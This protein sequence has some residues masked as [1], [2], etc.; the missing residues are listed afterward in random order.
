MTL[1]DTENS[2]KHKCVK[3]ERLSG[4]EYNP[5]LTDFFSFHGGPKDG[6]FSQ[7]A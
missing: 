5:I 7:G 2:L 4:K 3:K 6:F 1:S